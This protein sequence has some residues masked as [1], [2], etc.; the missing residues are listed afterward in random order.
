MTRIAVSAGGSAIAGSLADILLRHLGVNLVNRLTLWFVAILAGSLLAWWSH[1]YER[2]ERTTRT[3]RNE[4]K[5]AILG[6]ACVTAVATFGAGF[7]A[8]VASRWTASPLIWLPV[9]LL[10]GSV[11]LLAILRPDRAREFARDAS[12]LLYNVFRRDP[13]TGPRDSEHLRS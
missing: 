3:T 4:R 8:A 1:E 6:V 10:A 9:A 12:L 7:V 13:H 2:A 11:P 5:I